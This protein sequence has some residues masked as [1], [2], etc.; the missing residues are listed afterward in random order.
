MPTPRPDTSVVSVRVL[1]PGS[2]IRFEQTIVGPRRDVGSRRRCPLRTAACPSDV[3][4]DAAPVVTNGDLDAVAM[5]LGADRERARGRLPRLLA[6]GRRLEAVIDR[7]SHQVDQRIGQLLDDPLVERGLGTAHRQ[8]DLLAERSGEIA[9]RPREGVE[10]RRHRKHRQFDD[11]LPQF[12][13]D[14]RQLRLVIADVHEQRAHPAVDR[15]RARRRSRRARTARLRVRGAR[16]SSRMRS[17]SR[18]SDDSTR[19]SSA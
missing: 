2:K 12:L 3:G 8:L 16:R 13:G 9:N 14:Q 7:V 4:I 15:R 11:V 1:K 19:R 6:F 17:R 18:P 5:L 10:H